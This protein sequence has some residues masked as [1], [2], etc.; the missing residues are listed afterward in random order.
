[1]E[2]TVVEECKGLVVST[3]LLVTTK[4]ATV[5]CLNLKLD[6]FVQKLWPHSPRQMSVCMTFFKVLS[7]QK[8]RGDKSLE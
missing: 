2:L 8:E 4:R 6:I 3:S 1:M 7:A 5:M